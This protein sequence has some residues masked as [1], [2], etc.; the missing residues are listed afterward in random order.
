MYTIVNPNGMFSM[1]ISGRIPDKVVQRPGGY[2]AVL[3]TYDMIAEL[4]RFKGLMDVYN[5]SFSKCNFTLSPDGGFITSTL[6]SNRG[7]DGHKLAY[8]KADNSLWD[9]WPQGRRRLFEGAERGVFVYGHRIN[10]VEVK[11][12]ERVMLL[13]NGVWYPAD[14]VYDDNVPVHWECKYLPAWPPFNVPMQYMTMDY[15]EGVL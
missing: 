1:P 7:N 9:I 14:I 4:V 10:G 12:V 6:V 13:F 11:V 2:V 15:L 3:D 8:N 5:A